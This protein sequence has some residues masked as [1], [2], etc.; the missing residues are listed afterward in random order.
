MTTS[1]FDPAPRS[2]ASVVAPGMLAP[3]T[4]VHY[5]EEALLRLSVSSA[6]RYPD[7]I[8]EVEDVSGVACG[9]ER[10]GTL[11]VARDADDMAVLEDVGAFQDELGLAVEKLSATECRKLEPGLGPRI[12]GGMFAP[13]DHR[14]DPDALTRA[15]LV[16][17]ERAGVK[18]ID[19]AAL[20]IE[21]RAIVTA[22]SAHEADTIV[23]AAGARSGEIE[24]PEDVAVPVRPVKGQVVALRAAAPP[25]RANVR[26]LDAY[27]V[28]RPD[29]RIAI[30]ATMEEL[31]FDDTVTAQAVME[32]L[33]AA[34]EL[35]PEIA[36]CRFEGAA[37]G[38]RPGTPDNAPLIGPSAV[39]GIL[40]ATGHFRNGV[41]LTPVTADAI[42]A[43]AAGEEAADLEAFSPRRFEAA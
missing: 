6:E 15:L 7:F 39:P 12:R 42:G 30:G 17:C 31:G 41:L 20:R 23:L 28:A 38:F 27:V 19:E 21:P 43:L 13:D 9:Y 16:A 10:H 8:A 33:S 22:T 14:V 36:E 18:L 35:I 4:E 1:L 25:V 24:L 32:L 2:G 11:F 29:G 37:V 3:V 34:Y 26:G 5:G 40:I